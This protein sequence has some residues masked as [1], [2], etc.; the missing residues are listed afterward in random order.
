M[1]P[2]E[3]RPAIYWVGV[4]DRHTDLFEGLWPIR[5]EGISYNSYLIK[6]EK[7]AL[8]DLSNAA[9]SD[10]F[11]SQ[12]TTIVD[13]TSLDYIVIN[14][15]EPDHSGALKA[16]LH[17]APQA[18]IIGTEKTRKM[19]E[20]FYAI[21]ENVVVV[22]D[23]EEISLGEHTLRFVSTPFV[24]WPETMM[25]YE[26][27][28]NILFS[29]DGF[30]GYGA[31]PGTIFDDDLLPLAWYEEEAQRYFV[32][33]VATFSKPVRSAI[34]KLSDL[35]V[36][37]V[38]PS[39]GLVWRNHPERII[40]LYEKWAE[41]AAEPAEAR[42]TLLFGSMYGNTE[43]MMEGIAQGVVDQGLPVSIFD[44]S[45]AS[46]SRMLSSMWISRGILVGAPTYEGGLFPQMVHVLEL[47]RTKHIFNKLTA[48]FGGHAWNGGGMGVFK[49]TVAALRW[50]LTGTLEFSGAP[51]QEDLLK[52][53]TFGAEFAQKVK[54]V[55]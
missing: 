2:V 19:L 49:Q 34:A 10:E 11:I 39:H 6:D 43:K 5:D 4:N 53:R 42:V 7:T 13:P 29:C 40:D 52:G 50:D 18:K 21:T 22:G 54:D 48:G 33:I 30:G 27:K 17:L 46:V 45:R 15:M 16:L 41:Y 23:G 55:V 26:V 36:E 12:V 8:I 31:L 24:H 44:V 37:I 38:A 25:T 1:F 20:T 32:N 9:T 35:P 47:A 28:E 51:S 14:H 3:I